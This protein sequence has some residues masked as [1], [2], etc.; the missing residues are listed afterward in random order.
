MK[1]EEQSQT[2]TPEQL[3]TQFP[4]VSQYAEQSA[5]FVL[6]STREHLV[7]EVVNRVLTQFWNGHSSG[8]PPEK[9]PGAVNLAAWVGEVTR[10][11]A[12]QTL[13][14][15]EKYAKGLVDEL[16]NEDVEFNA[17]YVVMPQDLA[18]TPAATSEFSEKVAVLMK[19]VDTFE[20]VATTQLNDQHELLFE[21]Y[22]RRGLSFKQVAFELGVTEPAVRQQWSRL[23]TKVLETVRAQLRQD[24]ACADLLSTFLANEEVF[25]DGL[26]GVLRVVMHHGVEELERLVQRL[27]RC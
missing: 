3:A 17:N 12:Y 21:L 11:L 7:K 5:R 14:T 8:K 24:P 18:L 9:L 23:I 10:N 4:E 6:G 25:R 13:K 16:S 22:Y 27:F 1:T 2:I 26:L 19:V 15:E 20:S